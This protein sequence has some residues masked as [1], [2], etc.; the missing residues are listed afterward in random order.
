MIVIVAK[1]MAVDLVDV[2]KLKL[3][4]YM[5]GLVMEWSWGGKDTNS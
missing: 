5:L 1:V 2:N 4:L 3:H